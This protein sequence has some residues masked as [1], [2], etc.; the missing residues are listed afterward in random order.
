MSQKLN[1]SNNWTNFIPLYPKE[2]GKKNIFINAFSFVLNPF[3]KSTELSKRMD[4]RDILYKDYEAPYA[5]KLTKSYDT[6]NNLGVF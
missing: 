1:K 3:S 2:F 4:T 6:L 5:T